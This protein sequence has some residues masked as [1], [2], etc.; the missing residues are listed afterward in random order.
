MTAPFINKVEW[1]PY[2][3]KTSRGFFVSRFCFFFL[4]KK[5]NIFIV[6][7]PSDIK[8]YQYLESLFDSEINKANNSRHFSLFS[9]Y[10]KYPQTWDKQSLVDELGILVFCANSIDDLK[11]LFLSETSING[12]LG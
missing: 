7:K 11:K 10:F 12:K 9:D 4:S 8:T 6:I 1:Q 3:L 2:F 5:S